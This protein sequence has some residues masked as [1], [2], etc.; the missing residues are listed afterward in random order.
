MGFGD[1]IRRLRAAG[2]TGGAYL[3][4]GPEQNFSYLAGLKPRIAF[5]VDIR[6]QAVMQHLMFKAIFELSKDR[7]D[8]VS[9][10]FSKPRPLGLTDSTS[11]ADLWERY[12]YVTTDTSA[13]RGNLGRIL[14][15]LRQT[16]GFALDSADVALLTYVY[17]AFYEIGP[18]ID[19]TGAGSSPTILSAVRYP[20]GPTAAAPPPV[21][22]AHLP[23]E[24]IPVADPSKPTTSLSGTV[25]DSSGSPLLGVIVRITSAGLPM[26]TSTG[27]VRPMTA[28]TN[29]SGVYRFAD[30]PAGITASIDVTRLGYRSVTVDSI[31]LTQT[32]VTRDIV[33]PQAALTL[34]GT[35]MLYTVRGSVSGVVVTPTQGPYGGTNFAALTAAVDAGGVARSFL[36]TEE[37]YRF[38]KDL[39]SRN[40]FIPIVGDF[41]GPKAI[42][43][44]GEYLRAH[45]TPLTAFYTSNVEDYLFKGGT[46]RAFYDN[47]ATLPVT[48]ASV[49]IRGS[50]FCPISTNLAAI[51]AGRA[52]DLG[53]LT[54]C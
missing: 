27:T 42:R 6:R 51:A 20:L 53:T 29:D 22:V 45:D 18:R 49:F 48:P 33:L 16:H 39:Q 36:G 43:S 2:D 47:V 10:L 54:R 44:V 32:R 7:A 4:V 19:Y 28:T 3:G 41:S 24:N 14:G 1:V 30:L 17:T 12:W 40:L 26:L 23:P 15:Q 38:V 35:A 13:F 8:F 5:L 37:N 9:L 52:S 31:R 11:V 46:W 25:R 34:N 21:L 50:T